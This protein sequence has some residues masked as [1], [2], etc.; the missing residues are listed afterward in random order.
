MKIGFA[1]GP[2]T[3]DSRTDA[4]ALFGNLL[5]RGAGAALFKFIG[6]VAGKD[7]VGMGIHEA[8]RHHSARCVDDSGVFGQMGFDLAP[9]T[10]RFDLVSTDQ[11]GSVVDDRQLAHLVPYPGAVWARQRE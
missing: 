2:G 4:S 9:R 5:I 3:A 1:R 7:Q 8:G 11:H 6:A 10:H